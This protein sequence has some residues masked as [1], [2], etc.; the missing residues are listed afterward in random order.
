MKILMAIPAIAVLLALSGA[1]VRAE[2][3][4][5]PNMEQSM[6]AMHE[7]MAELREDIAKMREENS[8][9]AKLRM[10]ETHMDK[11]VQHMQMMMDAMEGK[12]VKRHDHQKM[13]K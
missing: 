2:S 13:K 10:M 9:E 4:A 3:D 11:M 6:A 8:D 5:E 1:P 12:Q 7:S